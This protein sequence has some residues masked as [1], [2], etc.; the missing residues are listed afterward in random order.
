MHLAILLCI[1]ANSN[2]RLKFLGK[3]RGFSQRTFSHVEKSKYLPFE[4]S[5]NLW[6][7]PVTQNL[8][9]QDLEEFE[10]VSKVRPKDPLLDIAIHKTYEEFK[11][12]QKVKPL[13]LNDVFQQDLD[14]WSKSPGLPWRDLGYKTKRDVKND[15][16]AV[17]RVRKFAHLIKN[18]ADISFPDC[19]ANVRSH[20]C[21]RDEYKVRAVW[22]YPATVTFIEA[23]FALPLIRG[24]Q[25]KPEFHRPIAYEFKTAT[26]GMK[27]L[28]N[29]FQ[30]S[31][32]W[33]A[34][35]D[36]KKFDKTVPPWLII[37]AF[38]ILLT[39]I[40]LTEYEE[41]RVADARKLIVLYCDCDMRFVNTLFK[42]QLEPRKGCALRNIPV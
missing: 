36:F 20:T 34:G 3:V 35:L 11:L 7:S 5:K 19:L 23:M 28:T 18:G 4:D 27:R 37:L 21:E 33:Y 42:Q 26:G 40:N 6:R 9:R 10:L 17:R 39:N 38:D 24:Y 31:D 15:P 13:H 8:I 1:Q 25:S 12:S 22:G 30:R 29:R 32:R 16:D 2:M 41:Y 14:I